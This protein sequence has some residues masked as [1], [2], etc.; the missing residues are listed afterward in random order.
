MKNSSRRSYCQ[1]FTI[2]NR[3]SM[4]YDDRT[5]KGINEYAD[6]RASDGTLMIIRRVNSSH[7]RIPLVTPM[8][9]ATHGEMTHFEVVIVEIGTDGGGTG[10][11]YTYTIGVGGHAIKTLIDEALT[12]VLIASDAREI[13]SLWQS[14][15]WRLHYVGRGGIASFAL[16]AVDVALWDAVTRA[17]GIPLWK[18]LGGTDPVVT[19]YAGGIDLHLDTVGLIAYVQRHLD[20]GFQAVKIK[21]GREQL[22]DDIER[23]AAVRDLVGDDVALMVDANMRW[24]VDTAIQAAKGLAEFGLVWIEEPTIPD[25]VAGHARIATE[26]GVPIATGEN[27]HT[28]YE[29]E[30]MITAGGISFPEPDVANIGGITA[31][32][33]VANLADANG[34]PVTTHGVHEIHLHLLASV[35]NP[36]LLEVHSFGLER[37][38]KNAP[39]LADGKMTAPS[40][41][42]HGVAFD[43]AALKEFE[44]LH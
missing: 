1:H 43:W 37:Y 6:F 41:P 36:S 27:L 11:G 23:V 30:K 21:V 32:K 14:M 29:F 40:E 12:P 13:E 33:Q 9:D 19:P 20:R 3:Q 17:D 22:S 7:Y 18:A 24:D 25:D 5:S 39:V 31:W 42:G 35:P 8:T 34:L 26:G 38:I 15:W 16:S 4:V 44:V 28:V 2:D 10:I